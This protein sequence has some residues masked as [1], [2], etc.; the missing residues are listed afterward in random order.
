MADSIFIR[1]SQVLSAKKEEMVGAVERASGPSL[2]RQAILEVDRAADQVERKREEAVDRREQAVRQQQA[3]R[4]RL[5][6]LEEQAR[7]ALSKGREDLA[8][9]AVSRQIDFEAELERLKTIQT[10]SG[11]EIKRYDETLAD[12]KVRKKQMEKEL[13]AFQSARRDAELG[14]EEVPVR[15]E[16]SAARR[17]ARAE[18]TFDR[19]MAAAGG[20]GVGLMDSDSAAKVAEVDAL[21]REAKVADRLAAFR[22]AQEK[23]KTPGQAKTRPA[24]KRK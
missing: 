17:A 2:M 1:V 11:A 24:A 5:D 18:A 3:V 22:A 6:T 15:P 14:N 8:E 9:A 23:P 4:Q 16:A 20:V 10:E 21:Q 19:A 13:A 7:F 12:L